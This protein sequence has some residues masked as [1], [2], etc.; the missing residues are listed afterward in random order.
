[1]QPAVSVRA[2]RSTVLPT[3][4]RLA[5][6]LVAAALVAVVGG[7]GAIVAEPAVSHAATPPWYEQV[8]EWC[9]EKL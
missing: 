2:A 9:C 5:E 8:P 6:A 7:L 1:M 3:S 4:T